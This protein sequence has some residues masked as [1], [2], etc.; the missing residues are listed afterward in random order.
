MHHTDI[1]REPKF[2]LPVTS[3][4]RFPVITFCYITH[5]E[6]TQVNGKWDPD[7]TASLA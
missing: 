4:Y 7:Y 2:Q 6:Q 1:H 5:D 3:N